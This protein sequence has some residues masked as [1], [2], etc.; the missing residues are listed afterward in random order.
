MCKCGRSPR[1]DGMCIGFHK[2]TEEQW[3]D[4]KY[5]LIESYK[6]LQEETSES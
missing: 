4:T 6:R 1:E 5:A 3:E 2:L